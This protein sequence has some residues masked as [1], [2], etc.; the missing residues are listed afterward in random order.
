MHYTVADHYEESA[1]QLPIGDVR[2]FDGDLQTIFAAA[3]DAVQ[4]ETGAAFLRRHR[5]ELVRRIAYWTGESTHAVRAFIDFLTER[6]DTLAL[7]VHALEASTLI[8]LTAFG[9]AVMMN[10]R[11]TDALRGGRTKDDE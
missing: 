9:T 3:P 8:E 7:R 10:Y 5:R 6:A 11:Y 1:E 2:Q 4:A